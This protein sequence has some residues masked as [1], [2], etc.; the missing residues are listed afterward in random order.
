LRYADR[1]TD[2]D[3]N[4]LTH[5]DAD[6]SNAHADAYCVSDAVNDRESVTDT[7]CYADP[8]AFDNPNADSY[9][10]PRYERCAR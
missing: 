8:N 10:R 3:A 5:T 9:A 7:N 2:R 6:A 4:L 1:L